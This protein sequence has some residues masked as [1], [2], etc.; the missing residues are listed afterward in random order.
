MYMKDGIHT[1]LYM[2]FIPFFQTSTHLFTHL[3]THPSSPP[4]QSQVGSGLDPTTTIGPLIT[5]TSVAA[6]DSRVQDAVAKG[7]QVLVGGSKTGFSDT[8][9]LRDGNFFDPTIIA[10]ATIDM[11]VFR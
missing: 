10:N 5:S 1:P 4:T 11:R 8:S 3:H 7:A 9:P 2:L 6:I